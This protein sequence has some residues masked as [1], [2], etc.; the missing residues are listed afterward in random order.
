MYL[1]A[2]VTGDYASNGVSIS[3]NGSCL[4][5]VGGYIG[6]PGYLSSHWYRSGCWY[7]TELNKTDSVL[8]SVPVQQ[9]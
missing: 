5:P 4:V 7:S 8:F 1:L 2:R 3:A 9:N 6:T